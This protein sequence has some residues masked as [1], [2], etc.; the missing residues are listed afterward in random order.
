MEVYCEHSVSNLIIQSQGDVGDDSEND[1]DSEQ[2]AKDDGDRV[3]D[4]DF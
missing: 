4:N 3:L 2:E 1:G